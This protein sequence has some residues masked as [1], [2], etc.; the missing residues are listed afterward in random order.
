M[1]GIGCN[2]CLDMG[3]LGGSLPTLNTYLKPT[4]PGQPNILTCEEDCGE[5]YAKI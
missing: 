3:E 1:N 5:G 4:N 2:R